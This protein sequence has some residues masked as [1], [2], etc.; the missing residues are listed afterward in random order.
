MFFFVR[1]RALLL[2]SLFLATFLIAGCA[3]PPGI[4]TINDQQTGF[5]TGRISLQLQSEP[6]QSFHAGFELKG[7]ARQG[8]LT[9][10]SPLGSILGVL[11][12]S[13][14][15]AELD[16]GN[17]NPQRFESVDA[18]MAQATGAAVPISAL[19]AWLRGDNAS[20]SGWTA[21][22]SRQSEGRITATRSQPAP[23]AE[24]RIVLDQ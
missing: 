6:V 9:L 18:L 16:S 20:A 21:D 17:H 1:L 3:H 12:W 23:R 24:L 7:E 22:L 10:I 8:E 11:R 14:Q 2:S 5:W 19:F 15:E 13:P 4:S